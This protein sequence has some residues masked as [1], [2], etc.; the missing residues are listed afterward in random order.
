MWTRA[1][2]M[3]FDKTSG[4]GTWSRPGLL[5]TSGLFGARR[6]FGVPP[7]N[8]RCCCR[9]PGRP[10]PSAE[11]FSLGPFSFGS[12]G[13]GP[14]GV[15]CRGLLPQ[16][17]GGYV[18][19]VHGMR[20]PGS[21]PAWSVEPD[22]ENSTFGR[23]SASGIAGKTVAPPRLLP[24]HSDWSRAAEGEG[25]GPRGVGGVMRAAR[26]LESTAKAVVW[27]LAE[28]LP[29]IPALGPSSTNCLKDVEGV[30]RPPCRL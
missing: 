24:S 5:C 18:R 30:G 1:G 26:F 13:R 12:K 15:F 19:Q 9:Q 21:F 7:A 3:S 25:P 17:S 2:R 27:V 4:V 11:R 20:V 8:T 14:V 16:Q 6:I 22:W 29:F 28:A 23:C 10:L